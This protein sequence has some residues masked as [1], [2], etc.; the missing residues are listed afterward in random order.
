M[1][2]KIINE[3]DLLNRDV[4]MRFPVNDIE[5]KAKIDG[6]SARLDVLKAELSKTTDP[7]KIIEISNQIK[8]L[9]EDIKIITQDKVQNV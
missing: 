7:Q 6:F 9:W 3:G 1:K 5:L 4:G 8:V 2:I